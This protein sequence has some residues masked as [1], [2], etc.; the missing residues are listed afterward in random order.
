M[1]KE[2]DKRDMEAERER[3]ERS[4]SC[5][6]DTT[7]TASHDKD[8]EAQEDLPQHDPSDEKRPSTE[9]RP[10][11]SRASSIRSPIV[12]VPRKERRGWLAHLALIPEVTIPT[13][14]SNKTK[15][16]IT[17][18]VAVSGAAAP[19]GSA[20]IL[21]ALTP[22]AND[23][24][25]TPTITNLSV[26]MYMLS[27]SIFPLWWSSFSETLGRRT[28]YIVSFAL[29]VVWGVLSAV[30]QNIAM[31]IVMRVL[32][33]GAAASVQAVGAGTIADVWEPKERGRA[34]GIFYLG[35]LCGPLLAPII[36]GAMSESLGWRSPL[37]F[38]VGYG[39]LLEVFLIF[40]L[41][42]T[43][44]NRKD[45][46]AE[47][48]QEATTENAEGEAAEASSVGKKGT[49]TRPQLQRVT[50]RQSVKVKT[51]KWLAVI[52]R[53][54]IDP[55]KIILLLRFPAVAIT[56]YYAAITFGSL[57]F[58]NISIE[59]TFSKSPYNFST[60]IVGL[61]YIPNSL[62]YFIASILGG[63]WID[64]IMKREAVKAGRYHPDGSGKLM[65]IPED[66]MKENAW[67]AAFVFPAA[68]IWY[69]WTAEFHVHWIVPVCGY[70]QLLHNNRKD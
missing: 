34:M 64:Y 60:L 41:P 39:V 69:G 47:A 45:V 10:K 29:F 55:L 1:S 23:L 51:K 53:C 2:T 49:A 59:T 35:P 14:Y 8:V 6:S 27:M 61:L 33:G 13:D 18:I 65:Y 25:S 3:V 56:V 11:L 31:L 12:I 21:P 19:M 22:I 16:L 7:T 43:L 58:L 66:R 48:Q 52:R 57:Y 37:W 36:G 40:C 9:L 50:T 20:I 32:S 62:G 44:K 38:L 70:P 15:W 68:L 54:F 63:R 30:A 24:H 67:I 26:A 5:V 17:A 46:V 42:E 28:I 4:A